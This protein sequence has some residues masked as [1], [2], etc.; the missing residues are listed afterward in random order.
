M[1]KD[2]FK[3]KFKDALDKFVQ[4][5]KKAFGKAGNAVQDFSD[6]SVTRIEKKQFESK[7][8]AQYTKLGK[9]VA[10][11]LIENPSAKIDFSGEEIL[12]MIEDIKTFSAEIKSREEV[13]SQDK[14]SESE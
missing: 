5:S 11:A 8:D 13:L 1:S 12:S 7:R 3:T 9:I 4:S 2:E 14:K 6:K 10:D